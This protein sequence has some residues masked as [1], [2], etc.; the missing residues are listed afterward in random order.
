MI[1]LPSAVLGAI[2]LMN[3]AGVLYAAYLRG[4]VDAT[5][6]DEVV[7]MGEVDAYQRQTA[8]MEALKG[9]LR[10]KEN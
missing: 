6:P 8:A 2:A 4:Q 5:A 10:D 1:D 3:V 7:D 9:D